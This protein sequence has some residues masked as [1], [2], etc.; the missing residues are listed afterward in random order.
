MQTEHVVLS[1]TDDFSLELIVENTNFKVN[2]MIG[3]TPSGRRK[4]DKKRAKRGNI[5]K[6]MD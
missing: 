6:E 4:S 1:Y 3:Q 5:M 2:M